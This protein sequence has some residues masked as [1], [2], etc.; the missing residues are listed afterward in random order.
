MVGVLGEAEAGIDDDGSRVDSRGGRG[1]DAVAQL[2]HD[3]ERDVV[4]AR[5]LVHVVAVP[6]PVHGDV[7]HAELGDRAGTSTRIGQAAADV[8]DDAGALG[9]GCPGALG[10]HGVDAHRYA[11]GDES[12]DHRQDAA[13]LLVER[14]RE[15][16]RPRRLA[17]DVDDV[18]PGLVQASAV[19]DGPLCVEEL[20]AVGEGVGGDVE[21][22]HHDRAVE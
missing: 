10:P 3:V 18:G 1:L 6:A 8:V 7:R 15:R 16:P 2:A 11:G 17:A 22:A 19:V 20:A 14:T 13:E 21:D 5:Q 9:N 4:V 12:G